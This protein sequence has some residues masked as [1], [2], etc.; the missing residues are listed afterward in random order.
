MI[1][2][3]TAIH[4]PKLQ[5]SLKKWPSTFVKGHCS[6]NSLIKENDDCLFT[7]PWLHDDNNDDL[8]NEDFQLFIKNK[9]LSTFMN[10]IIFLSAVSGTAIVI[11][12]STFWLIKFHFK[13][14]IP[15]QV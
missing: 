2:N 6:K 8:P 12:I 3:K 14:R 10:I 15:P 13:K 7:A 4:N 5:Y 11:I 9:L 1:H